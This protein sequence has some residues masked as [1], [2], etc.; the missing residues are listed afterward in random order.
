MAR[1]RA[2]ISATIRGIDTREPPEVI[3]QAVCDQVVSMRDMS[4][5]GLYV[6]ELDGQAAQY[7][8]AAPL[9]IAGEPGRISRMATARLRE[10]A[11]RGPWIQDW[12]GTQGHAH[13]ELYA[14]LGVKSL[15]YAPVR[16]GGVLIGFLVVS[17]AI[18][19]ALMDALPAL[20]EFADLNATLIGPK[21][22]DRTETEAAHARIRTIIDTHAFHPVY[23]P[24]V[25]ISRGRIVGY[26]ALTRFDD[27]VPPDIHFAAAQ[28]VGMAEQLEGATLRAALDGAASLQPDAWL[29]LNVSPSVL[30]SDEPMAALARTTERQLVVEV[31]ERE[32]IADYGALRRDV[33]RL[34]PH[35]RLAIDDAGAGFASLRHILE[36]QAAFVKLDRSLITG[37]DDDRA[38]Q[39]L[40]AGMRH[41][42]RNAGF[43]LIAEGIETSGELA[44]LRELDITFAQ[45]Y[46]LGRPQPAHRVAGR[47][48]AQ[49]RPQRPPRSRRG[50]V[51]ATEMIA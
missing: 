7:G 38:K 6:F 42:A 1:E 12:R 33:Q 19:P 16:Y 27:K 51:K 43:W 41:F 32:S 3:A 4:T 46:L 17:S 30:G 48:P 26:E 18:Q 11:D 49:R 34:G 10:R 45:G 35:V 50:A 39:A 9:D 31:T 21:V 15:A 36:L 47:K 2:L 44:A 22:A 13:N 8:F 29:S 20:V 28:A 23:Q 25:D 24:I 5:A 14:L 40:V 37:I